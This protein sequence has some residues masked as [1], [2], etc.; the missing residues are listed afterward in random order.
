MSENELSPPSA[1][2]GLRASDA[3]REQLVDELEQHAIDDLLGRLAGDRPA[4]DV[5][6]RVA[7]PRPQ[8]TQV[9]VDLSDG[10]DRRA[11][12]A[13]GRLLVDRDRRRQTLDRVDVGLVH[14]P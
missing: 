1:D 11:R 14:L 8:Q 5:T 10:S 6:V 9:V 13:R 2:P 7:D 4:T 12:V 3:D